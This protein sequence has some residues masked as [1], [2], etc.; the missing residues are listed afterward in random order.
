MARDNYRRFWLLIRPS[1]VRDVKEAAKRMVV[2]EGVN[3]SA[4]E[5]IRRAIARALGYKSEA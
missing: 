2:K 4:C 3:R 5:Y 1:M